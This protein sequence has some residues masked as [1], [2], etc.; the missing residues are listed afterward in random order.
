MA[1]PCIGGQIW[2]N[3]AKVCI[4]VGNR[5]FV[6]GACVPPQTTCINGQ[7]WDSGL[8]VCR[9]LESQWYNG[10]FC[11]DIRK[12]VNNQ[13][14]NPLINRCVCPPGLIFLASKQFCGDP[15]CPPNKRWNGQSCVDL[16]CPPGSFYN[17]TECVCPNPN[18]RCLPW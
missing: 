16:A 18:S 10:T 7:I 14:Y 8:L 17:G 3:A 2:D 9:C 11:E 6:N 4:C 13:V 5:V 1:N 15:T 12:C